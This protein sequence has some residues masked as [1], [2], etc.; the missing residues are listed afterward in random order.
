[1]YNASKRYNKCDKNTCS[2]RY[3]FNFKER[4]GIMILASYKIIAALA[5]RQQN[6][7]NLILSHHCI[8]IRT[9]SYKQRRSIRRRL[10]N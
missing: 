6:Y 8:M 5:T 2:L 1:M 7:Y 3:K 9:M 4:Q 10:S